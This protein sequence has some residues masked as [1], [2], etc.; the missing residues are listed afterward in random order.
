M[1]GKHNAK[2]T[3]APTAVGPAQWTPQASDAQP[4]GDGPAQYVEG[5]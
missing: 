3:Q 2:T 1:A 5:G 4:T